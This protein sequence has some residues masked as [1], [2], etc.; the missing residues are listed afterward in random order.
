MSQKISFHDSVNDK[1]GSNEDN[2]STRQGGEIRTAVTG[3]SPFYK[4]GAE[5][6]KAEVRYGSSQNLQYQSGDYKVKE[7]QEHNRMT[8]IDPKVN[9]NSNIPASQIFQQKNLMGDFPSQ[10][11]KRSFLNLDPLEQKRFKSLERRPVTTTNYLQE[12]VERHREMEASKLKEYLKTNEKDASKP[13]DK[14]DWPGPKQ[15]NS[16][17]LRELEQM[18]H[19][20]ETL[21]KEVYVTKAKSMN[22]LSTRP[23]PKENKDVGENGHH[24]RSRSQDPGWLIKLRKNRYLQNVAGSNNKLNSLSNRTKSE[25]DI[26]KS[27]SRMSL[28]SNFSSKNI[29]EG[30]ERLPEKDK[31]LFRTEE[32]R[33]DKGGDQVLWDHKKQLHL[34]DNGS[35][36]SHIQRLKNVFF[37]QVRQ[38][39][40]KHIR[41]RTSPLTVSSGR[42]LSTP[43]HH[44]RSQLVSPNLPN[45]AEVPKEEVCSEGED[46][47]R[48]LYPSSEKRTTFEEV[49]EIREYKDSNQSSR[50]NSS[51][52]QQSYTDNSNNSNRVNYLKQPINLPEKITQASQ[53]THIPQKQPEYEYHERIMSP[54][55]DRQL[56]INTQQN[57]P[58]PILKQNYKSTSQYQEHETGYSYQH[59]QDAQIHQS[60][61]ITNT[62]NS[63]QQRGLDINN[64][65]R[66]ITLSPQPRSVS[67][68]F[69]MLDEEERIRIMQENLRK[70]RERSNSQSRQQKYPVASFNGP[71]F[72]LE[73]VPKNNNEKR[74]PDSYNT[75]TYISKQ[76]TMTKEIST[77]EM[78]LNKDTNYHDSSSPINNDGIVI[79]PPLPSKQEQERP[80][81]SSAMAR[82]MYDPERRREFERQKQMEYEAMR[83]REEEKRILLEKQMKA[84]QIQQ[85]KLF[86]QQQKMMENESYKV[87]EEERAFQEYSSNHQ[88]IQSMK[89]SMHETYQHSP[90]NQSSNLRVY[91]TRPI[92]AMSGENPD[93]NNTLSPTNNP[94]WKRTYVLD[95]SDR[96]NVE[97]NEIVTSDELLEKEQ[98]NIDIL[99]RREAFVE[100]P[101]KSP[102]IVR[103]GKRWQPPPDEPYVWPQLRKPLNINADG[104]SRDSSNV[105]SPG[106]DDG[107]E[108]KWAPI[109][110]DPGF[111]KENKN[112]TPENSPP[113]SPTRYSGLQTLDEV[114]RRQTKNVIKPAPDG[115]H[116]PTPVFKAIRQ[117]PHGGFYPHAP[118]GIRVVKRRLHQS[119]S[120][121]MDDQSYGGEEE[122]VQIIHERNYHSVDSSSKRGTP[123]GRSHSVHDLGREHEEINDWEKIYDLPAHSST[124]QG[125]DV[126]HNVN[127]KKR[128]AQFESQANLINQKYAEKVN[129]ERRTSEAYHQSFLPTRRQEL[130]RSRPSKGLNRIP[131]KDQAVIINPLH[132]EKQRKVTQQ[133]Q[134][135]ILHAQKNPSMHNLKYRSPSVPP[136]LMSSSSGG[137]HQQQN[138]NVGSTHSNQSG[139][140]YSRKQQGPSSYQ[141]HASSQQ[142]QHSST[143]SGLL[144]RVDSRTGRSYSSTQNLNQQQPI[145]RPRTNTNNNNRNFHQNSQQRPASVTPMMASESSIRRIPSR[146]AQAQVSPIPPS[147][148]TARPYVPRPLPDGYR[149]SNNVVK[150]NTDEN[151]DKY[152]TNYRRKRHSRP[153]SPLSGYLAISPRSPP[154]QNV[155]QTKKMA[156]QLINRTTSAQN[157]R[158]HNGRQ[159]VPVNLMRPS[160]T[161]R[162]SHGYN[163]NLA[164]PIIHRQP[165][166]LMSPNGSRYL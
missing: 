31:E 12:S 140:S 81:P 62:G 34:T 105:Y 157:V 137:Y 134:K 8:I 43:S 75:P 54:T 130:P 40:L 152:I 49:Q 48:Y 127:L 63:N 73:E 91:E 151:H 27:S 67:T 52:K 3:I 6:A 47:E 45:I 96:R 50:Y 124:I 113:M 92:S 102:E 144:R 71:F 150:P 162:S 126:P 24:S 79:W 112:F 89:N 56:H 87:I 145:V 141:H 70:H 93:Y 109:V 103:L 166:S 83:K 161:K 143:G 57:Q 18:K 2:P 148:N 36:K 101:E 55:V 111:R 46:D 68:T 64:D 133:Q 86:E 11:T 38:D 77:S 149:V 61:T 104:I 37:E 1:S 20:I 88:Q 59:Y 53:P 97:K 125:K 163:N 22:D 160:S 158:H 80:R 164:P 131:L 138:Q 33:P 94:T 156:Q 129:H 32:A 159:S 90:Q 136:T 82:S 66:N 65:P 120:N 76:H 135:P 60:T 147:Y 123:M 117:T 108:Y 106:Q 15:D 17:S 153:L 28:F 41:H 122:D 98:Y 155:G 21:Q 115:S 84:M 99:K 100:K 7:T 72:N 139:S 146:L 132:I 154:V 14:P 25:D 121:L 95:P 116:R 35:G 9:S 69:E 4:S 110:N 107:E 10:H 114:N 13:W 128:L 165:S 118:N 58:K 85:Q 74:Q 44:L 29:S 142:P 5:Q 119:H 78:E 30:F 42:N 39:Q 23:L 26:N 16:E 51:Q 19:A